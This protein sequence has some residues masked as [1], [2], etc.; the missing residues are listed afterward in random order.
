MGGVTNEQIKV[1]EHEGKLNAYKDM[2]SNLYGRI[3][4]LQC[5]VDELKC[6]LRKKS[7]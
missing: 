1:W 7:D 4:Q 3:S 2:I 6:E 5:E